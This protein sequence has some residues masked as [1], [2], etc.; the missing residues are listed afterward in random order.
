MRA[1]FS[2]PNSVASPLGQFKRWLPIWGVGATQR[3][4]GCELR[5][6]RPPRA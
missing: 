4:P 1:S 6:G 5:R 3:L 2:Q